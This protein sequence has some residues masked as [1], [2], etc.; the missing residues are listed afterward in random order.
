MRVGLIPI[1]RPLFRGARMGLWERSRQ[2][3]AEAA[4]RLGFT[5]ALA[6]E[7]VADEREARTQA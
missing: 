7:P 5:L 4:P 1:V 3:L 2:A 6:A